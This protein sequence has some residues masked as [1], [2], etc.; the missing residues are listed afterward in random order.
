MRSRSFAKGLPFAPHTVMIDIVPRYIN[1]ERA[2]CYSQGDNSWSRPRI[3]IAAESP[4]ALTINAAQ[5]QDQLGS[6]AV[7]RMAQFSVR[8]FSTCVMTNMSMVA[9]RGSMRRPYFFTASEKD[10]A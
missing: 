9:L 4:T 1:P 7:Q 5:L 8:V 10:G 3:V 6:T 2:F